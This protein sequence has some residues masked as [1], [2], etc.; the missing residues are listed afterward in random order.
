MEN[1]SENTYSNLIVKERSDYKW[2]VVNNNGEEIVPFGKYAW[3]D[4]FDSGLAR[5]RTHGKL[6]FPSLITCVIGDNSQIITDK[7]A[8]EKSELENFE[9][10]RE[11]YSYW[12]IINEEG[13]EVLPCEYDSIWNFYGKNKFY[14]KVV[15]GKEERDVFFHDLNPSLPVRG[16]KRTYSNYH[17]AN[18]CSSFDD[19]NNDYFTY[20]DCI[21]DDGWVDPEL[22]YGAILDGEYIP[23]YD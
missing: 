7:K 15:K 17:Y 16:I 19:D 23:D 5:V 21:G 9:K 6:F 3:I 22:L 10:H 12:G 13:E 2:G 18:D 4:G 8:I 14:T 20:D 11:Q 1:R